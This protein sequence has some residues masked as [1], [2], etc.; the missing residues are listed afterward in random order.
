MIRSWHIQ[1][2]RAPPLLNWVV[3][4]NLILMKQL[5]WEGEAPAEPASWLG[6]SFALPNRYINPKFAL[7]GLT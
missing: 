1:F 5:I 6:R 3:K 2:T 7:R 4:A